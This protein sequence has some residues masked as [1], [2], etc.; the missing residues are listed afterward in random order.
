MKPW[1]CLVGVALGACAFL[2]ML[3]AAM[4]YVGGLR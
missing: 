2:G 4:F 3:A 1:H